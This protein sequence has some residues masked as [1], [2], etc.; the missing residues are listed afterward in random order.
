MSRRTRV[1]F[2][3]LGNIC[4]SPMAEGVFNHRA[5]ER[6]RLADFEVD[7]AGTA[8]YHSGEQADRRTRALLAENGIALDC[9]AR[10]VT[11]RDFEHYDY[12]FAMD[13]SNFNT[14]ARRCPGEHQHKVKMVL[15]PLGGGDVP[16]P[17]YGGPDGFDLNFR[18][19]SEALDHWLDRL[20]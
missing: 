6:G 20:A 8:A 11:D 14:L 7:S 5:K 19:L 2:V 17:Y 10:Q 1:L 15:E 3:C 16:D 18:Q 13:S 12:I 9:R 4:R